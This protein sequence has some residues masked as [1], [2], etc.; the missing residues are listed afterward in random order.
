MVQI[1]RLFLLSLAAV[2]T[3]AYHK[4]SHGH[5]PSP[6][7]SQDLKLATRD[8]IV[9]RGEA[10]K[11]GDI[12]PRG[13]TASYPDCS[14]FHSTLTT[15]DHAVYYNTPLTVGYAHS[16]HESCFKDCL[17][18]CCSLSTCTAASF[19][20]TESHGH[21]NCFLYDDKDASVFNYGTDSHYTLAIN[22][23][24]CA[25]NAANGKQAGPSESAECG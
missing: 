6:A 14:G 4:R 15:N 12:R 18:A 11:R 8:G 3:Q 22:R 17:A 19:D 21:K 13:T 24:T 16:R 23:R 10:L 7:A 2:G 1:V 20:P 9:K 5:A 25:H